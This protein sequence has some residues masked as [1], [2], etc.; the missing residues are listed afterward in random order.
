MQRSKPAFGR[1]SL[2]KWI[3]SSIRHNHKAAIFSA[4]AYLVF[5]LEVFFLI[6][7]WLVVNVLIDRCEKLLIID[8]SEI[9]DLFHTL[10]AMVAT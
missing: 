3:I 10:E 1:T 8:H 4:S 5:S 9:S 7:S 6:M 2:K